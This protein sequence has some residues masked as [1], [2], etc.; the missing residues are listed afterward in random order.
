MQLL[1]WETSLFGVAYDPGK[2]AIFV[3]NYNS[4]SISVI[5]DSTNTVVATITVENQPQAIAY[6]SGKGEIFVTHSESNTVSVISDSSLPAV[7][8]FTPAAILILATATCIIAV[9]FRK[10][11]W[12]SYIIGL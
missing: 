12:L 5:S 8:E 3:A 11:L 1:T 2:N 9:A 10:K 7:P 6:D 4:N